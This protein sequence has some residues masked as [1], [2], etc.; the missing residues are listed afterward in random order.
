MERRYA[1]LKEE[2]NVIDGVPSFNELFL[3]HFLVS[4]AYGLV[5]RS[6]RDSPCD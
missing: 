6:W 3:L 4:R 5:H 1:R 2:R